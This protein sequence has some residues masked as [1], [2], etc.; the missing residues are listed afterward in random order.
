MRARAIALPLADAACATP[1][2]QAAEREAELAPAGWVRLDAAQVRAGHADHTHSGANEFGTA[3]AVYFEPDRTMRGSPDGGRDTDRG[4]WKIGP[5]GIFCRTGGR[6]RDAK[7][8]CMAVFAKPG[9]SGLSGDLAAIRGSGA[10]PSVDPSS[11]TA[12]NTSGL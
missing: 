11:F 5:D 7:E 8:G 1:E 3:W 2:E 10:L 6:W 4:V 12:E 9:P